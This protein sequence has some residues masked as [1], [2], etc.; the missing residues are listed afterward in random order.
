VNAR[1]DQE[2][3][4]RELFIPTL[5]RLPHWLFAGAVVIWFSIQTGFFQPRELALY[6]AG[7]PEVLKAFSDPNFGRADALV[8]IFGTLFLGPF[9]VF[10]GI[11]LV[12]FV[13]AILGGAVLPVTRWLQLPDSVATAVVAMAMLCAAWLQS[14]LWVPRSLWFLSLLARAWRVVLA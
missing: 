3:T 4:M 7:R 9:A 5:W 13:M 6:F 11:V 2:V 8:L 10:I 1:S 14:E 12:V